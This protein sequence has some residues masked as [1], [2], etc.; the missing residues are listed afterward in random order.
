MTTPTLAVIG[1]ASVVLFGSGYALGHHDKQPPQSV[2]QAHTQTVAIHDTVARTDTLVRKSIQKLTQTDTLYQHTRDTVL[3]H[4][5]DTVKVKEFVQACDSLKSACQM[6]Q[7]ASQAKFHADSLLFLS[8]QNEIASW[9]ALRPNRFGLTLDGGYNLTTQH[10]L[11]R[12]EGSIGL[13]DK[14][15]AIAVSSVSDSS[16]RSRFRQLLLLRYTIH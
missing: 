4:L 3:L 8:Y 7:N 13:S 11:A 16:G 15:R 2:A 5:T 1:V 9:K 12:V 14:L 10:P 6:A